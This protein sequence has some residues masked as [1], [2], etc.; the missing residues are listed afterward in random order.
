MHALKLLKAL[1]NLFRVESAR[2]S[3]M[4][5][6]S[7]FLGSSEAATPATKSGS[8]LAWA[9]ILKDGRVLVDTGAYESTEV[10][11]L[12]E[13]LLRKSDSLG[14]DGH[15]SRSGSH[16]GL[17]FHLYNEDNGKISVYVFCC[18]YDSD[19]FDKSA[20]Q[21][22]LAKTI[23]TAQGLSLLNETVAT[24]SMD[25]TCQPM[26]TQFRGR[27]QNLMK[28]AEEGS[29]VCDEE[30]KEL[31]D[32][33]I[34]DNRQVLKK[35]PP[36][37]TKLILMRETYESTASLTQEPTETEFSQDLEADDVWQSRIGAFLED[38]SERTRERDS[39]DDEF[40]SSLDL[41]TLEDTDL[42]VAT[43]QRSELSQSDGRANL[44]SS[45]ASV[46]EGTASLN[47]SKASLDLQ[48]VFGLNGDDPLLGSIRRRSVSRKSNEE[49]GDL[50]RTEHISN[51]KK[52]GLDETAHLSTS[53]TL[54]VDLLDDDEDSLAVDSL[55]SELDSV[56]REFLGSSRRLMFS[57]TSL[58]EES[59]QLDEED[60][61]FGSADLAPALGEWDPILETSEHDTDSSGS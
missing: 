59:L 16:E 38:V 50:D 46:F 5:A 51:V 23:A 33:I 28:H 1:A 25:T 48:E 36:S 37:A 24:T 49:S 3:A 12:G 58:A 15:R 60:K 44:G 9:C 56:E 20:A 17:R 22:F 45:R 6:D 52:V 43:S 34:E 40:N 21:G 47:S 2:M 54:T 30:E 35:H 7:A 19:V 4:E 18:I 10:K 31:C 32:H 53:R 27:L 8:G 13:E 55:D 41:E 14:W 61:L 11:K 26:L 29:N 39:S 57:N 42:G